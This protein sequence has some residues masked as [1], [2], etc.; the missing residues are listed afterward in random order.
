MDAEEK[1]QAA[2]RLLGLT[3]TMLRA[4]RQEDWETV[5]AHEQERRELAHTL[6]AEPLPAEA[7]DVVRRCLTELLE[8]DPELRRRLS[9]SRDS[10][11]QAVRDAQTGRAA[12]SAYQRYSR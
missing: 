3:E 10:A 12:L 9:E 7:V 4:A 5:A 6:F 11:A 2:R 8:I 1:K